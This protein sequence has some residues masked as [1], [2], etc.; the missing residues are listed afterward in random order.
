MISS[1]LTDEL[2]I[3]SQSR[4][5]VY[6]VSIK[7]RGSILPAGHMADGAFWF[8]DASG[9]F[10]SSSFY[11]EKLPRWAEK[12]NKEKGRRHFTDDL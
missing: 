9:K 12:F 11:M 7:D 2:K 4:S 5:K 3:A 8:D 1:S 10:V 6:S